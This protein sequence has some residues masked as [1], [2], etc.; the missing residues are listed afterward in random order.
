MSRTLLEQPMDEGPDGDETSA[1]ENTSNLDQRFAE[2]SVSH[3]PPGN[4]WKPIVHN[5]IKPQNS[6]SLL[7]VTE[8]VVI[9]STVFLG[10]EDF[11]TFSFYPT[12]KL[13]DFGNAF[14]YTP[15]ESQEAV[16]VGGTRTYQPPDDQKGPWSNIYG[17]GTCMFES[18]TLKALLDSKITAFNKQKKNE[19]A[20]VAGSQS[21]HSP[22]AE[23]ADIFDWNC[24]GRTPCSRRLEMLILRCLEPDVNDRITAHELFLE[25]RKAL[26]EVRDWLKKDY[27]L[28][29]RPAIHSDGKKE[30][31]VLPEF[32]SFKLSYRGSDI[33]GMPYGNYIS[34]INNRPYLNDEYFPDLYTEGWA[35][36]RFPMR[37]DFCCRLETEDLDHFRMPWET[38]NEWDERERDWPPLVEP[39]ENGY[40][41]NGMDLFELEQPASDADGAGNEWKTDAEVKEAMKDEREE[42]EGAWKLEASHKKTEYTEAK[43]KATTKLC[44]TLREKLAEQAKRKAKD[45]GEWVS[46]PATPPAKRQKLTATVDEDDE[47]GEDDG[48]DGE[49]GEDEEDEGGED[50]GDKGEEGDDEADDD[51]EEEEEDEAD[52]D[53][54]VDT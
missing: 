31:I 35:P 37:K 5:D 48:E 20:Q 34:D 32:C 7:N 41:E 13:G 42:E 49:D 27:G 46:P 43:K 25:T 40:D 2:S 54:D 11:D 14:L 21:S 4:D 8:L 15:E 17:V 38:D 12:A 24:G 36:M 3:P 30:P 26:S 39:D 50:E 19:N 22:R 18:A 45:R 44:K 29:A 53:D 51:H 47:G 52:D 16:M 1:D 10:D 9:L 23:D 6:K 28:D 33:E